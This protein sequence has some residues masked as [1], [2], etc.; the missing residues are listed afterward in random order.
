LWDLRGGINE[1]VTD[2][3]INDHEL[4][5]VENWVPDKSGSGLLSKRDGTTQFQATTEA[6]IAF[7]DGQN[8]DY[9]ATSTGIHTLPD[10][11]ERQSGLTSTTEGVFASLGAYD[12]YVNGN[13]AKKS[14]DG[15]SWTDVANIPSGVKYIAAYNQFIFATGHDGTKVRWSAT[16]DPETWPAENE[17]DLD[18]RG[19]PITGM[20][21]WN[22]YVI[23][24]TDDA[25]FILKGYIED[26]IQILY[27]YRHDGCVSN[28]SF[29]TTEFGLFWW[30]A[31]GL[32][33][34]AD[35]FVV[36]NLSQEKL[37]KTLAER[38]KAKDHLVHGVYD[39]DEQRVEMWWVGPGSDTV[40]RKCFYYPAYKSF[41]IGKG[42]GVQ[43]GASGVMREFG[44]NVVYVGDASTT[45]YVYLQQGV[46]DN[47]TAIDTVLETKRYSMKTPMAIKYLTAFTPYFWI[48]AGGTA[49]VGLFFDD[50]NALDLT[51]SLS[52]TS[53]NAFILDT[54]TLPGVLGGI[55]KVEET[56]IGVGNIFRKI[57]FSLTESIV[58][59]TR[60]GGFTFEGNLMNA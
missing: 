49:I 19:R 32:M 3:L 50:A 6:V 59:D 22:D 27:Q 2:E 23:V 38:N 47:G 26:Q 14:S 39:R 35:G 51:Y 41:W 13:E 1:V 48:E 44:A 11:I 60:F 34:T 52:L 45:G 42:V 55:N 5:K 4:S 8:E 10:G 46:T 56:E 58:G 36:Q 30:G 12:I 33:F 18:A 43:M 28:R 7:F 24:S 20:T 57:K 40:N 25:F 54:Q 21:T 31:S 15:H 53:G 9:Y 29:V 16:G 17:W 37:S